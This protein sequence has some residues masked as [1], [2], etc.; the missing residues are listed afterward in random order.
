MNEI[1]LDAFDLVKDTAV[2]V[3]VL[4]RPSFRSGHIPGAVNLPFEELASLAATVLPDVS[5]HIVVYCGGPHCPL[6]HKAQEQLLEIGYVNVAHYVGGLAD[7]TSAGRSLEREVATAV[8]LDEPANRLLKIVDSLSLAKWSG[9]WVAMVVG[10]AI[11]F[12]A[13]GQTSW[14]GLYHNGEPLPRGIVSIGDCLYFSVVTATTLGYG[15]ITLRFRRP[16]QHVLVSI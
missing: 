11:V 1:D 8:T 5:A 3:D 9:I 7:W 16:R 2:V 10:C 15:D 12:W 13:L 4:P 6:G 14:A